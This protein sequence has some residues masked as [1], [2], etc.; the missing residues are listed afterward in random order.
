MNNGIIPC[1]L[2][3]I[4]MFSSPG[5]SATVTWNFGTSSGNA[6]PSSSLPQRVTGG[7][8]SIGNTLG[9]VT[10][11]STTSASSGYT[12]A[13]G[14]FNAG[15][16]ART[17]ALNT[18]SSGSA[19]FEFTFTPDTGYRLVATAISFGTR[20]TSTAPQAFTLRSSLD[21]YGSDIAT[22]TIANNST[23]TLKTP[24][25]FAVTGAVSAAVSFRI[26]GYNGSGTATSGTINW[27]ID[28]LSFTIEAVS[29]AAS[30]ATASNKVAVTAPGFSATNVIGT[31]VRIVTESWSNHT[32]QIGYGPN[33]NGDNWLWF[34][35]STY[36]G[37][38]GRTG[39]LSVTPPIGQT[40]IGA[41][42]IN[43]A[44]TNY[45]WTAAGQVNAATLA[46]T[47]YVLV[48][49]T[50]PML[51]ATPWDL[52]NGN[53]SGISIGTHMSTNVSQSGGVASDLFISEYCEGS[54]NNKYIEIFNGTGA[55]V[56]MSSYDLRIAF[57]G[58]TWGS[59]ISLGS[60]TLTTG[61]VFVIAN[62]SANATVLAK[63]DIAS[64]SITFN[65]DDAVGLF[66]DAAAIDIIGVQ[67]VDPG[68][69][70]PVGDDGTADHTLVRKSGVTSG[71]TSWATCS[72]EWL[73][74]AV[75]TFTY[76]GS[77]TMDS[78]G[79]TGILAVD[80][81]SH[82]ATVDANSNVTFAI[83]TSGYQTPGF[84]CD[85]RRDG[86]GP[87]KLDL[88]FY[89]GSSWQ[90]AAA[91]YELPQAGTW[92]TIGKSFDAA[93][94]AGTRFRLAGYAASASELEIKDA[95]VTAPVPEPGLLLAAMLLA[96]AAARRG[97]LC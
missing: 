62:S 29:D 68:T 45:G 22:G 73:T 69:E 56:S 91:T 43:G 71:N 46:A 96:S 86:T 66:K 60:S 65:G 2:L 61:A 28:D 54:S 49:N 1:I 26:Y 4:A 9:T 17:G 39:S 55:E 59:V 70:W 47:L 19:Y 57:N 95:V 21:S 33:S 52:E 16:A 81:F 12:G 11:L 20:S 32:A 58:G 25:A 18:G 14:Q 82:A 41:R 15:N 92:Y 72:N 6:D 64:G 10:M 35:V 90:N 85:V 44:I 50:P 5:H 23:W 94:A 40:Y 89:D 13:S 75:D 77:H 97:R 27:R 84:Y 38:I 42:W 74:Y 7:T 67:G 53:L 8:V 93:G 51:L 36:A 79:F 83:S 80:G 87:R 34:T 24:A 76:L 63:A 3:A 37:G 31:P 30:P 48:T 78:G 88:D